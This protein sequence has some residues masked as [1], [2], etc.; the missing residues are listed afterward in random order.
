M[1]LLHS[2]VTHRRLRAEQ[3]APLVVSRAQAELYS[4]VSGQFTP[5][6]RRVQKCLE[7]QSSSIPVPVHLFVAFLSSPPMCLPGGSIMP[8]RRG[9]VSSQKSTSDFANSND[10]KRTGPVPR[11]R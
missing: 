2:L 1:R 9:S 8:E 4:V 11:S 7:K 3:I 5:Q 6:L 10:F